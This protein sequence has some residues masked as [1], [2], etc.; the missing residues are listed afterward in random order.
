MSP[1]NSCCSGTCTVLINARGNSYY[2][3]CIT[4][5][6][7]AHTHKHTHTQQRKDIRKRGMRGEDI[8]VRQ[9][10]SHVSTDRCRCMN[11]LCTCL[12]TFGILCVCV[13]TCV[14]ARVTECV[15]GHGVITLC[16]VR[17]FLAGFPLSTVPSPCCAYPQPRMTD[18][19]SQAAVN[20][21]PPPTVTRPL[22]TKSK[23]L[24]NR[25]VFWKNL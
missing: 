3:Y 6:T 9:N 17:V 2:Y 18:G 22:W 10:L 23:N 16:R 1:I 13:S 7:L 21:P 15:S 8:A 14:C 11:A 20:S 25:R 4:K 19:G 12:C 24:R 5:H